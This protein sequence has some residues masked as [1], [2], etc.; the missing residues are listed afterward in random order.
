MRTL[1]DGLKR[2]EEDGTRQWE[3]ET[4]RK[5]ND[6]YKSPEILTPKLKTENTPVLCEQN[7]LDMSCIYIY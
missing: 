4:R 7:I 1:D 2:R 5:R 3:E 6:Y